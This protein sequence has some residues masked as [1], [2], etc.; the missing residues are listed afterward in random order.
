MKTVLFALILLLI[1]TLPGTVYAQTDDSRRYQDTLQ[2]EELACKVSS[3]QTMKDCIG[4]VRRIGTPIVKLIAPLVCESRQDCMF[5]LTNI[6]AN[7]IFTSPKPEFKIIRKN[8]FGYPLFTLNNTSGINFYALSFEDKDDNPCAIGTVC[9]PLITIDNSHSLVFQ[10]DTFDKIHGLAISTNNTR[11]LTIS[12]SQFSDGFKGAIQSTSSVPLEGVLI[13]QNTFEGNAGTAL[14]FQGNSLTPN[15]TQVSNNKFINNHSK[16]AYENCT[17]PCTGS[18]VKING[19]TTNLSFKQNK[20]QGGVNTVFD[21]LG[22]YASGVQIGNTNVKSVYLFCNEITGN[23]GSGV[24]QTPPFS[25]LSGIV[26]SENKIWGNGLNLNI[27]VAQIDKNNCFAQDCTQACF[28]A[29]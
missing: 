27:P 21:S 11:L 25:N 4:E 1:Q 28:S 16:G 22:L 15:S 5:D 24:V 18:Q 17:Y 6:N 19:P 9:P 8:D 12:D 23:R 13:N 26:I 10:R 14:S 2:L 29:L 7:V 3:P 20:V